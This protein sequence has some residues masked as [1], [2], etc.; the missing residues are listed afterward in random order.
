M[1]KDKTIIIRVEEYQVKYLVHKGKG[2]TISQV[3]RE[4]IDNDIQANS[5]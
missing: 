1:K 3:V 4:M 5:K 2:K